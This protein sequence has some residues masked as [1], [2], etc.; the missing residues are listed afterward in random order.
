MY[1]WLH[2]P[3]T[4]LHGVA[5]VTPPPPGLEIAVDEALPQESLTGGEDET[6]DSRDKSLGTDAVTLLTDYEQNE[7][8]GG[9]L[10]K[11]KHDRGWIVTLGRSKVFRLKK[12]VMD[13]DLLLGSSL[14]TMVRGHYQTSTGGIKSEEDFA[15]I[16]EKHKRTLQKAVNSRRSNAS[17]TLKGYFLGKYYLRQLFNSFHHWSSHMMLI[18]CPFPCCFFSFRGLQDN[19][20][21]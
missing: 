10:R 8:N 18:P 20:E 7:K 12:F 6:E 3:L 11:D 1:C 19:W 9:L 14:C 21:R 2:Y 5:A 16:W 17:N 13:N 15:P 4:R